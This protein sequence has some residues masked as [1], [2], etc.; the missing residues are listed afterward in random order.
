MLH[1]SFHRAGSADGVITDG[2]Y[3]FLS[4]GFSTTGPQ[5][6]LID[7]LTGVRTTLSQPGCRSVNFGGPFLLFAC[8]Y[9]TGDLLYS[10]ASKT[11]ETVSP[12]PDGEPTGIGADWIEYVY[13]PCDGIEHCEP[14]QEEDFQN[15]QTGKPAG[16]YKLNSTTV[17]D[18]NSPTLTRRLCT[19]VRV[20]RGG[21]VMSFYGRFAAVLA[22]GPADRAVP[23][24]ER[25]GSRL[26]QRLAGIPIT[27]T[28]RMLI[29]P[30]LHYLSGLLLPSLRRF[31]I[32]LPAS[33]PGDETFFVLASRTLYA[34]TNDRELWT[35]RLPG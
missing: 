35:A 4:D 31:V 24:L 6:T 22:S 15:L 27:G 12:T 20:P 2:R 23:Y 14:Q 9:A 26:H 1:L 8:G 32:P 11:W 25:C 7:Q 33:L 18:L 34:Q 30:R 29:W 3:V 19:P 10:L 28:S 21:V 5:G 17:L 16:A 13:N